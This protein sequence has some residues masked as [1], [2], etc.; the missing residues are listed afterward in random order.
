MTV[1]E[2][3][4]LACYSVLV[5][6]LQPWVRRKLLRRAR[7][8]PLYGRNMPQRFGQYDDPPSSGWCWIH[9][10]S[11]GETRAAGVLVAHWRALNPDLRLLLTHGTATGMAAGQEWLRPGDRQ[12]WLPWDS[13]GATRAFLRHFQPKI[14]VLIE[15]EVWPNLVAACRDACVLLVLANA[16]LNEKTLRHGRYLRWL[17]RPAYG[18]FA[19]VWA[20][21]E[22]DAKRLTALGAT[23]PQ[24]L[25]NLKQ[26]ARPDEGLVALGHSWRTQGGRPVVM[27]AS[28]REGEEQLWLQALKTLQ[29]SR[30][31][32]DDVQWLVVPR[33]PQRVDEVERLIRQQGLTVARRSHWG[34]RPPNGE[35]IVWLGDSMGEMTAYYSVSDVALLGGS[36]KPLGGQNLLEAAATGCPVVMGLHTFNFAQAAEQLLHA[37][38]AKRVAHMDDA[39]QAALDWVARPDERLRAS[40]QALAFAGAAGGVAHQ[41]A[42]RLQALCKPNT[43]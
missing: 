13:A 4:A 38:A 43:V 9:A 36:F 16:R 32:L 27:L 17:S 8:E 25:G 42:Q 26:D 23:A 30:L 37:G 12:V 39:V 18:G 31:D 33:H 40:E 21:T 14:G 10:V 35:G 34:D 28:T 11:L 29:A 3:L 24:V 5:W 41:M 22:A 2:R 19:Q 7:N 1:P 15:T 20:Q 6:L